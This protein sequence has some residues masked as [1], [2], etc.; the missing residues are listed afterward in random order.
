MYQQIGVLVGIGLA[1]DDCHDSKIAYH[2]YATSQS[3]VCMCVRVSPHQAREARATAL[4]LSDEL[5][6][7]ALAAFGVGRGVDRTELLHIVGA[8]KSECSCDTHTHK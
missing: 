4:R 7:T 8:P 6:G 5:S 2:M 1:A 3:C